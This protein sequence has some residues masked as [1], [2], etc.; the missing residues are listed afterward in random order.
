MKRGLVNDK[1]SALDHAHMDQMGAQSSNLHRHEVK[2]VKA[3]IVS[4]RGTA[5]SPLDN[6]HCTLERPADARGAPPGKGLHF[7]NRNHLNPPNSC[8][9]MPRCC[10]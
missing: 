2:G 1:I 6:P 7:V 9:N 3:C 10:L 8:S 4:L 5:S